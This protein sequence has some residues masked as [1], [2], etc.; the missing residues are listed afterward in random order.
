MVPAPEL[1]PRGRRANTGGSR[2]EQGLPE[3]GLDLWRFLALSFNVSLPLSSLASAFSA[4]P[5][6]L[7]PP[8]LCLC[9]FLCPSLK[10]YIGLSCSISISE[11]PPS[12]SLFLG[13]SGSKLLCSHLFL[14]ISFPPL[15]PSLPPSHLS[16]SISI[17]PLPFSLPLPDPFLSVSISPLS[18]LS[19]FSLSRCLPLLLSLYLSFLH[20]PSL[21]PSD[22][23]SVSPSSSPAN[24]S[25]SVS[26]SLPL[27]LIRSPCFR[28]LYS[29]VLCFPRTQTKL[30]HKHLSCVSQSEAEGACFPVLCVRCAVLVC[31]PLCCV[32]LSE[33]TEGKGGRINCSG[34]STIRGKREA[35]AVGVVYGSTNGFPQRTQTLCVPRR[36]WPSSFPNVP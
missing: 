32:C 31:L 17:P 18:S 24:L 11:S 12:S 16:L 5:S 9:Q 27:P 29:A 33:C 8:R 15:S 4:R 22:R 25:L 30:I 36:R 1:A 7:P 34:A 21:S 3:R 14:S 6:L 35:N 13:P 19:C 20:Y 23:L 2:V 26:F 10:L 28:C